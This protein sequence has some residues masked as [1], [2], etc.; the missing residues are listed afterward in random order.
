MIINT[1]CRTDIPAF[2]SKWF[3]NRIREGYVLVRNPY[4]E[5]KVTKYVLDSSVVDYID[6]CT[7]NPCP[8]IKYMAELRN[9]NLFWY[10]TITLYGK[11]IEPNV[12]DR[13]IVI[14]GVKQLRSFS[15]NLFVGW[16]YDLIFFNDEFDASRH[17]K[18]FRDIASKL[19]GYVDCCVIRNIKCHDDASP[20]LIGNVKDFEVIT[21][22]KQVS[23][24]KN[25]DQ[26]SLF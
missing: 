14:D 25:F 11:D 16:R 6:F 21:L 12:P 4:F 2:Y 26:L 15:N 5:E 24:K 17:I 7:K 13:D 8:M 1:G 9:F 10:V 18:E 3:I 20:L 22:S 19:S 23:Y